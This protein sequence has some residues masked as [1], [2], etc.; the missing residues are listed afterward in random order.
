MVTTGY[1]YKNDFDPA[2]PSSNR[3]SSDSGSGDN[4]Q[5]KL[6]DTLQTMTNY[7]LV[8]QLFTQI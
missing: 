6:I 2:S 1:L 7:T 5:F 8:K 4:G 3:I